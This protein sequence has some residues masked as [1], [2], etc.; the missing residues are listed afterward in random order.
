MICKICHSKD[1]DSTSGICWE[2]AN[3][4]SAER[5]TNEFCLKV[6]K[7]LGEYRKSELE[8]GKK[9]LKELEKMIKE[10]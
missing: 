1:T 9:M 6:K 2:C 3:K 8:E 10:A 5:T 4:Q 7:L